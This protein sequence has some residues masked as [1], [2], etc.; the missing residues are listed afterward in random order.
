MTNEKVINTVLKRFY[1]ISSQD[2]D[3]IRQE[4]RLALWRASGSHDPAKSQASTYAYAIARHACLNTIMSQ[5][6]HSRLSSIDVDDDSDYEIPDYRDNDVD[7]D[8][9]PDTG[10]ISLS[11]ILDALSVQDRY[12]IT[13]RYLQGLTL[14]AIADSLHISKQCLGVKVERILRDIR[15]RLGI[16]KSL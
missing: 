12:I 10:S 7:D 8:D 1:G 3:D 14:Q 16:R 13:Q 4:C 6:R 5:R 2:K 15:V 9:S 11:R